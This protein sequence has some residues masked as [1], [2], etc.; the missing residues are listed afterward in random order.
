MSDFKMKRADGTIEGGLYRDVLIEEHEGNPMIEALPAI[1]SKQDV[2]ERVAYLPKFKKET[3]AYPSEVRVQVVRGLERIFVPLHRHYT[4]ESEISTLLRLSYIDR[5]NFADRNY[6]HH[7]SEKVDRLKERLAVAPKPGQMRYHP[8]GFKGSFFLCGMSGLGKTVALSRIL[9]LYPQV[10]F[11]NRYREQTFPFTQVVWLKLDCPH[12]S[13]IRGLCDKFFA[14][15]D[16]VIG[17]TTFAEDC[18]GRTGPQM[19]PDVGRIAGLF[20]SL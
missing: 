2:L 11:H 6:W 17:N 19:I 7:L 8:G 3:L 16:R 14:E 9:A 12:N 5:N 4:L 1:M 20:Y 13:S 15:V 18:G 10:I